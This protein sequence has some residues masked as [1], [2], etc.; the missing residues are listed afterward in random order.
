[1]YI[2]KALG[3]RMLLEPLNNDRG[4]FLESWTSYVGCLPIP[5]HCAIRR[6]WCTA[7]FDVSVQHESNSA[8]LPTVE[9]LWF[10]GAS[11]EKF[12][13]LREMAPTAFGLSAERVL[14]PQLTVFTQQ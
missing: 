3:L 1:A 8:Y 2:V 11:A 13:Q 4:D 14:L 7:F 10:R 6:V 12:S 5:L 9:Q